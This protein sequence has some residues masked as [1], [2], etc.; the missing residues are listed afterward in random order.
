M[1]HQTLIAI[2]ALSSL[3]LTV[4]A[5]HMNG[6]P[7]TIGQY[8]A[9]TKTSSEKSDAF[10]VTS[11]SADSASAAQIFS[12]GANGGRGAPVDPAS[13]ANGTE[14][15]IVSRNGQTILGTIDR[16][17]GARLFREATV[18][19]VEGVEVPASQAYPGGTVGIRLKTPTDGRALGM[20][21]GKGH[22]HYGTTE[23]IK[24]KV[25]N[26]SEAKLST[27]VYQLQEGAMKNGKR[28][29]KLNLVVGG[30]GGGGGGMEQ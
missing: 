9:G 3:N 24:A 18:E 1:K 12:V 23:E 6:R 13:A 7:K 30:G 17:A 4:W 14:V 5:E 16:D 19:T 8:T 20:E 2:A 29:T 27:V 10:Q 28:D 15:M 21:E 25:A 26:L 11:T 22:T